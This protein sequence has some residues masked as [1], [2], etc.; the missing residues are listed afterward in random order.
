[1]AK[2]GRDRMPH[3]GADRPDETGLRLVEEWIASLGKVRLRKPDLHGPLE[4]LL[5]QPRFAMSIARKLGRGELPAAERDSLHAAAAKMPDG[6]MRDLFEGYLPLAEN[7]ARKLGSNPRP[8]TILAL[9]GDAAR[10]ETL[11][12]SKALNCAACHTI[13]GRGTALGPDLTTIGKQRGRRELLESILEPSRRIEPKYAVYFAQ[14]GDGRSLSGL[15]V[16]RDE[17]TVVLRDAQNKEIVLP[18]GDVESLQP[19]RLSLMPAAQLAG[20]TA[21]QAADLLE[22]LAS[23]QH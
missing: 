21:Q 2:F 9:R 13:A 19:S 7:G 18:A 14:T 5:T 17:Q 15:L 4:T 6:P 8:A 23:R 20:L 3:I 12:W 1:M 16:R 10:G 11:F 22:Y